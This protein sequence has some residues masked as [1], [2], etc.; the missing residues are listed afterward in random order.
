MFDFQNIGR[1]LVAIGIFIALLGGALWLAGR[2]PWLGRLPG[3]F[4]FQRGNVSCL[5]P[6]ATSIILSL[7]LTLVLNLAIRWFNR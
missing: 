5:F 2:I 4:Q 1:L 7:I 3:D 6:L